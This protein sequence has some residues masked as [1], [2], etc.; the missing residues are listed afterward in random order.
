MITTPKSCPSNGWIFQADIKYDDG[1]KVT[2][3]EDSAC[4]R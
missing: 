3:R 4:R 1:T 2:I